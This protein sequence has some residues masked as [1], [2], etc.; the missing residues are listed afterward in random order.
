MFRIFIHQLIYLSLHRWE[1]PPHHTIFI[2]II[3]LYRDPMLWLRHYNPNKI[4]DIQGLRVLFFLDSL[5]W[6]NRS[7]CLHWSIE[8][9]NLWM[10]IE[11]VVVVVCKRILSLIGR[12][13]RV[14]GSLVIKFNLKL[15]EV[16]L[17]RMFRK[18]RSSISSRS[19]FKVVV[20][21]ATILN[22]KDLSSQGQS[23]QVI[24]LWL[25]GNQITPRIEHNQL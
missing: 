22:R 10:P 11:L 24:A 3:L 6:I 15:R 9:K 17:L 14:L 8:L 23:C 2:V 25:H 13:K 1:G 19:S 20:V 12:V 21:V 5:W 16:K 18:S 7:H 4:Q